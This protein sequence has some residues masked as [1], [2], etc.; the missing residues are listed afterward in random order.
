MATLDKHVKSCKRATR[1]VFVVANCCADARSLPDQLFLCRSVSRNAARHTV[2]ISS[3]LI[4]WH[5]ATRSDTKIAVRVNRPQTVQVVLAQTD[6]FPKWQRGLTYCVRPI[7]VHITSALYT[8]FDI[9]V[10]VYCVP[11]YVTLQNCSAVVGVT[12]L[13]ALVLLKDCCHKCK[14][15]SQKKTE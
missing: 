14:F 2:R 3:N 1:C 9:A 13:N 5:H 8:I 15:D 10:H 7:Y 11:T 12:M 4:M 6:V